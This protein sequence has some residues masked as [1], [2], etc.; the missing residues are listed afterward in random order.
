MLMKKANDYVQYSSGSSNSTHVPRVHEY[1]MSVWYFKDSSYPPLCVCVCVCVCA[2]VC[3]CMCVCVSEFMTPGFCVDPYY[4]AK[5][6][7]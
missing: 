5:C 6:P 4:Q 1:V 3:V 7:G 2:C